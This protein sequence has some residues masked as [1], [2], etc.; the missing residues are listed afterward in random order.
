MAR[1]AGPGRNIR[2]RSFRQFRR[3]HR[4]INTGTHTDHSASHVINTDRV[5][6]T[7]RPL[8][9]TPP[10]GM[11]LA[12]V[13]T[14]AVGRDRDVEAPR[15]S[16]GAKERDQIALLLAGPFRSEHPIAELN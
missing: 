8:G 11:L 1:P 15:R 2:A 13:A 6:G 12:L 16:E 9:H 5:F 4:V 10:V 7:H 14:V 3:F